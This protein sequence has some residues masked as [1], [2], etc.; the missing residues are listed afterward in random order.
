MRCKAVGRMVV[1]LALG[2]LL[3]VSGAHAQTVPEDA[4]TAPPAAIDPGTA[5]PAAVRLLFLVGELPVG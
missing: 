5:V 4:A 2:L 1:L 3:A